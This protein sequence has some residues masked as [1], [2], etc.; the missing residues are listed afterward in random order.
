ME[1]I[2]EV[3]QETKEAKTHSIYTIEANTMTKTSL[4]SSYFLYFSQE[5]FGEFEN[6]TRGIVFK[7]LIQIG[8]DGKGIDKRRQGI[9]SPIVV[10]P[11]IEHEGIS[12]NGRGENPMTMKTTF[13]KVKDMVELAS[14]SE[15]IEATKE[16]G[17]THPLYT[18]YGRL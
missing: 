8:Y 11:R 14:S 16:E 4:L 12:F 5:H 1:M 3:V 13:L 9:L 7:L 2:Q 6:H 18:S 15:Y 17:K 10:A